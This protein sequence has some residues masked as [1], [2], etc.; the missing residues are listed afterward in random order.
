MPSLTLP[1][2]ASGPITKRSEA[3]T[4]PSTNEL[5]RDALN[6]FLRFSPKLS[7]RFSILSAV[8]SNPPS[9]IEARIRRSGDPSGSDSL[10][11]RDHSG[12]SAEVAPRMVMRPR[13]SV[14]IFW[15]LLGKRPP[16]ANP[17]AAPTM[18]V[19]KLNTVPR[20]TNMWPI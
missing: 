10:K 6:R 1:K 13:T 5:S 3:L 15:D 11:S 4:N 12:M 17:I 20:P 19:D 2:I 7:T 18:M 16:R 14:I 9:N 8:P